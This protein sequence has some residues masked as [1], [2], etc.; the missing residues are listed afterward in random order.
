MHTEPTIPVPSKAVLKNPVLFVVGCQRSGTTM[1]QRMLD[2]HPKLAVAYDSLF[3]TRV[4]KG[5]HEGFDPHLT[6]EIVEQARTH[7]RFDRLGL[8]DDA[9]ARAAGGAR[10]YSEFVGAIYDE[11]ARAHGKPF[12]GEKSPGY[13]RHLPSLHALLPW[14]KI[15]HLIRDGRDVA[16]SI[17]DWGKGAAKLE[18]WKTEPIAVGALWWRRDVTRGCG[19]GRALPREIYREVRYEDVVADPPGVMRALSAFLGLEYDEAMVEYHKGRVKERPGLS[20]KA[21]WLP[22]TKGIRDWRSQMNDRDRELFE[23]IAGE[24]LS[25]LGYERSVERVSPSVAAVA[26][27][28]ESWWRREMM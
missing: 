15:V 14:T 22:P 25:M 27:E 3:I 17:R 8:S 19:S 18:L 4:I 12:A 5:K 21:A 13:C 23:A 20:A 28:C 9:V 7:P 10:V 16:L 1:L 2:A 6:D 11:L 26:E 24:Q